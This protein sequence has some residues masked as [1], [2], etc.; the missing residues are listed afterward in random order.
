MG[1]C[2][3]SHIHCFNYY[4]QGEFVMKVYLSAIL[5]IVVNLSASELSVTSSLYGKILMAQVRSNSLVCVGLDPDITQIDEF[6]TADVSPVMG[7]QTFLQTVINVVAPHACAY[8]LNDAF[9]KKY[10]G[11][12][13]NTIDYIK[14]WYPDMPIIVDCKVGDIDN[15]LKA[16]FDYYF[17]VLGADVITLSPYM[18]T[19]VFVPFMADKTKAGIIVVKSSNKG[20]VVFQDSV[21]ETHFTPWTLMLR[22]AAIENC[23]MEDSVDEQPV[24]LWHKVLK[25]TRDHNVC[26]NLMVVIAPSIN[27]GECAL[28]RRSIGD[29]MPILVPG[30]GAQGGDLAVVK[31]LLNSTG[32]GVLVNASRSILYPKIENCV[33]VASRNQKSVDL[34]KA[35]SCAVQKL[36]NEINELRK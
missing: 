7:I 2:I 16:H 20:S 34:P 12:L 9:Y 24:F 32:H 19:E 28:I 8:K 30:I 18:G 17:D 11:L 23:R 26:K 35:I 4:S 27:A 3:V 1:S 13:K 31:N 15:T 22:Q 14:Q 36:K 29:E 21:L 6:F 5:C 10:D 33:G 25:T